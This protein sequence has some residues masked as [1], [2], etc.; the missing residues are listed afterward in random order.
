MAMNMEDKVDDE[1]AL[2]RQQNQGMIFETVVSIVASHGSEME[3][4]DDQ[5]DE[6]V[7]A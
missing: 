1:M 6:I 2:D 3:P 4:G 7:Q 5:Y